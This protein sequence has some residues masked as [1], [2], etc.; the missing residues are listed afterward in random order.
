MTKKRF[1]SFAEKRS[2]NR[3]NL[4]RTFRK[5]SAAARRTRRSH[6]GTYCKNKTKSDAK[7]CRGAKVMSERRFN[8]DRKVTKTLLR[9]AAKRHRA[10]LKYCK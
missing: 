5:K 4:L 2:K 1:C 3:Q 7:F 8:F 10:L 9:R 6:L